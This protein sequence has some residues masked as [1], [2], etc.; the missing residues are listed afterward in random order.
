[1]SIR[2]ID[3]FSGAG[4]LTLGLK[5]AGI[6]PISAVEVNRAAMETYASH[7]PE[8]EHHCADIREV[9]LSAY[10][11]RVDLVYGGPPCQP[12]S[13]GGLRNGASDR[14]DMIPSFLDVVKELKPEAVLIENVPGLASKA[15]SYYLKTVIVTLERLG[16]VPTWRVLNASHYGVPQNRR[17][18]FV[19]ALR[20]KLFRFPKATHGPEGRRPLVAS[21]S[22][23]SHEPLGDPPD[24]PV[25]YAKFPDL[26]PSPY[27]GH[28]Y[29]GGGRPVDLNAPCHTILASAGGYKTH[30]VDTL[31]IAVEYHRYLKR[32]GKPREGIVPGARRLTVEESAL[33]QTFP[34]RLKFF[35]SRSS[36]YTQVGDAVPPRLAA[37]LGRALVRQMNGEEPSERTHY[38]P[39]PSQGELL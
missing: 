31:G 9:N 36:R 29:N 3:L 5:K 10:K 22:V 27:A 8:A 18:L 35:G 33:V 11:G 34:K 4:G 7:S 28:V 16:Y 6:Q 26:R 21:S 15:K 14:R 23:I 12:F 39:V 24:C 37:V 17:R 20:G 1:M 38:P 30:W 25:R 32:G 2:A 13:I 19:I